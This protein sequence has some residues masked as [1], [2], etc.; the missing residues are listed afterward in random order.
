VLTREQIESHLYQWGQEVSSNSVEVH[1]S[2]L[3]RKLH[4][5]VI[6]TLRGVGYMMPRQI[7]PSAP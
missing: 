4:S 5:G 2:N 6:A 1:I 3:R 7:A